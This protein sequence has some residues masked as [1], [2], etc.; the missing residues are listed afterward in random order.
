MGRVVFGSES[1]EMGSWSAAASVARENALE[2]SFLGQ[3]SVRMLVR[4]GQA[5][6]I[7]KAEHDSYGYDLVLS[8]FG[9][10]RHVQMKVMRSNGKRASVD[11]HTNLIAKPGGCVIWVLVDPGTFE[12][13]PY[14]WLGGAPGAPIDDLGDRVARHAKHNGQGERTARPR[15]REVLRGRFTKLTT[16]DDVI[17]ALFG[18]PRVGLLRSHLLSRRL[19]SMEGQGW[20]AA[21]RA[22]Y[23]EAIPETLSWDNSVG[24]AHLIDGYV[25]VEVVGQGDGF[26]FA[27][28]QLAASMDAGE[29]PGDALDLWATLFLEHRR[30]RMAGQALG[31]DQ[32]PLRETLVRQLR[33]SLTGSRL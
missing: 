10:D 23:F 5:P 26:A 12:L 7:L 15:L 22:G 18:E 13:G 28:R 2:H 1:G 27:D 20:L 4:F 3:L 17:A 19:Q 25:L 29:W 9:V 14:L 21:V 33:A 16:I 32:V 24:L 6:E 31:P 30:E 8:A 11:V